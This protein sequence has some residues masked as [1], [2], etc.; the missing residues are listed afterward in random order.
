MELSNLN[1]LWPF[2]TEAAARFEVAAA[3]QRPHA[4]HPPVELHRHVEAAISIR[5]V[6]DLFE[7]HDVPFRSTDR[8]D[9]LPL[10]VSDA[11]P[12]MG[13]P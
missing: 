4:P 3:K 9:G 6:S 12:K 2:S 7:Q 13:K 10:W 8:L 11:A 1:R 5:R